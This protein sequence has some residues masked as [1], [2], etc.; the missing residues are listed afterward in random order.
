MSS[1]TTEKIKER[2]GIEEVV[3]SYVELKTAGSYRK[4]LC[5]FHKEKTPSFTVSP[6]RGT[7]YCFGCGAKGDIFTFVQ[8][9][10]GLDF[11]GALRMLGERAGVETIGFSDGEAQEREKLF[12]LLETTC[13]FFEKQLA[14]DRSAQQYLKQ[15][16]VKEQTLSGWR[17]GYAWPE[18]RRLCDHLQQQGFAMQDMEK[19]GVVKRRGDRIYDT[20]RQ[21][22][23]FPIMD[24]SG[25]VIGFSGRLF[26]G[27]G[28][29][30][31]PK[32]LNSPDSEIYNKSDA[33]YGLDKAKDAIRS[34]NYSVLVEG[35]LDLLLSHQAGVANTVAASGTALTV[36]HL[37][38]LKRLSL[39]LMIAFDNDEAGRQAAH[40]AA[41]IGLGEG[42]EV[43]IVRLPK[44]Q[45]PADVIKQG[46]GKWR[47]LLK[48]AER[49]VHFFASHLISG[50]NDRLK[51]IQE[52]RQE[53]FPLLRSMRG[54]MERSVA[55]EELAVSLSLDSSVIARD[56]EQ[57]NNEKESQKEQ[58]V[59]GAQ[60]KRKKSDPLTALAAL[61][62]WQVSS[63]RPLIASSKLEEKLEECSVR[64]EVE[65]RAEKLE[66]EDV[67]HTEAEFADGSE[68]RLHRAVDDLIL[69]FK[70][71]KL[72]G[73]YEEQKDKLR[74]AEEQNEKDT[75]K[76][77]L[78]RCQELS[79]EIEQLK[80]AYRDL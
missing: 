60:E 36:A 3:G 1:K 25:R 39:N 66:E 40:R 56:L 11:T 14:E 8:Q 69:S 74:Q 51:T 52:L 46:V 5:P 31:A 24:T 43:K 10:E 48:A 50:S 33:V 19:V 22:I 35:Q 54:E 44:D 45:D 29:V 76:Q 61:Y 71:K 59:V 42:M 27:D 15:R 49:P 53:I 26:P 77:I 68:S 62:R 9:I 37:K 16:G 18:W 6:D 75:K 79:A 7:F 55:I 58:I 34:S 30:Q 64:E 4:G 20:F 21:R 67:F 63:S 70:I 73:Q 38:R 2:L 23:I 41:L 32:Y 57:S 65:S 80:Q 13:L 72:E 17:I 12:R 78:I 28:E 47:E